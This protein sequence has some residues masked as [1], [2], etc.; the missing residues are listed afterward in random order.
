MSAVIYV[1]LG[2]AL[3]SVLRYFSGMLVAQYAASYWGTLLVNLLGSLLIGMAAAY[4]SSRTD[5][6]LL[7][8]ALMTGI[9]GGFTT[10]SAFSLELWQMLTTE[11]L[12]QAGLYMLATLVGA[13]LATGCGWW[14]GRGLAA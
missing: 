1:A 3:G 9:L 5:S 7:R 2:G 8:L 10:L 12:L 11:R 4:F 13:V 6:P 14:L